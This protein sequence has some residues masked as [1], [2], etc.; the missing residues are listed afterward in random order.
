[1]SEISLF[2][3]R[4]LIIIIIEGYCSEE[5]VVGC[6]SDRD[7]GDSVVVGENPLA[8]GAE[9]PPRLCHI[10]VC[11]LDPNAVSVVYPS[12][13]DRL[14]VAPTLAAAPAGRSGRLLE[15]PMLALAS[16]SRFRISAWSPSSLMSRISC[17]GL[18]NRAF[19]VAPLRLEVAW[20]W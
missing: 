1:V 2:I 6:A 17:G 11:G 9:L 14:V 18:V 5:V 19:R 10:S 20:S 8:A 12:P 4:P 13:M 7:Q 16:T 3:D 15:A